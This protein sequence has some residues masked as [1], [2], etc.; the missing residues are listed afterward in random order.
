M[1]GLPLEGAKI[2]L[3]DI[4]KT[5]ASTWASIDKRQVD[6]HLVAV[7]VRVETLADQR[8]QVI[9]LPSTKDRLECLD[10]HSVQRRSAIEQ[11]RMIANHLI[12]EYPRL[13]RPCAPSIFLALL[14]V[15]A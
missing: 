7:E 10:A 8:V 6:R 13:P 9:A 12:R 5:C 2:L 1:I 4:I 3:V 15:S 14:I 11:Y